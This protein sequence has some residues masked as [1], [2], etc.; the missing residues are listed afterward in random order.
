M[1]NGFLARCV[2]ISLRCGM[3]ADPI[4][5]CLLAL[6]SAPL[7]PAASADAWSAAPA[8]APCPACAPEPAVPAELLRP[9]ASAADL[10]GAFDPDA[11]TRT[12]RRF[13][14]AGLALEGHYKGLLDGAW[15]RMSQAALQAFAAEYSARPLS[16]ADAA[17]VALLTVSRFVSE[18]WDPVDIDHLW[19]SLIL[20]SDRLDL[21]EEDGM[22]QIW[23]HRDKDLRIIFDDLEDGGLRAFHEALAG[24]EAALSAPYTVRN[25]DRW[26]TSIT[27]AEAM[28][29][30][31]SE[32]IVGTWSTILVVAG[33]G[34]EGEL[35]LI[36]SSIATGPAP[37]LLP[38]EH[39]RL[40][41]LAEDLATELEEDGGGAADRA[42]DGDDRG[43]VQP[44]GEDG[45]PSAVSSGT[46][47]VIND[48][49]TVLT[50][51]HV[52]A[53]CEGIRVDGRPAEVIADGAAFDLAALRA[54]GME[55]R[56]PLAFAAE[57]AGLNAD[58]T[59]A[60]YPLH[61]LLGGL[62]VARGSVSGRTGLGGDETVIQISAPV[63]HGNSGGPAVDMS[64]HV[65]AVVVAKLDALE[66]ADRTGDIAQNVNF[67]IRGSIAKV[68]LE[69]NDIPFTEKPSARG[70]PPEA[71][72]DALQEAT[73]LVECGGP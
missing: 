72:A 52:I 13:L 17:L 5:L 47:F 29:Y 48:A 11:L 18:G 61:G 6:V 59:V 54:P 34:L 58:I 42:P 53:S 7:A 51:A 63:Q 67:A 36:T 25:A 40:M 65:T 60:G 3:V 1:E 10:W 8:A 44:R 71:I 9:V 27:T 38:R 12:E 45:G 73:V 50:N 28:G 69:I 21:V 31:R 22:R 19:L 20:P 15:G 64:G 68:F 66:L 4:R 57:E 32:R 41:S 49:G 16:N 23:E 33:R 56:T 24:R 14:Q 35:G 30:M 39:G 2:N 70:L 43:V 37:R 46:G 55:D 62:N 26:V